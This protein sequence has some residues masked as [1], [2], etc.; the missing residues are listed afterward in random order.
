MPGKR[1]IIEKNPKIEPKSRVSVSKTKAVG[2]KKNV[3][4]MDTTYFAQSLRLHEQFVY[5]II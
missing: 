1:K 5:T 3:T 4:Y 2:L